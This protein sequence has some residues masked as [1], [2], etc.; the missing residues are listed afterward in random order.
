MSRQQSHAVAE[1]LEVAVF[2]ALLAD[3]GVPAVAV[4]VGAVIELS[5]CATVPIAAAIV[6][7]AALATLV[8]AE[9]DVAVRLRTYAALVVDADRTSAATVT[10]DRGA[11]RA[12]ELVRATVLLLLLG[13]LYEAVLVAGRTL[14]H[15]RRIGQLGAD[16][17]RLPQI[18]ELAGRFDYRRSRAPD[19]SLRACAPGDVAR[20]VVAAHVLKA[21]RRLGNFAD[22]QLLIRVLALALEA[23]VVLSN[24]KS[25]V[26]STTAS[27]V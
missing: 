8:L 9:S 11:V 25:A 23:P 14:R 16:R 7:A 18:L 1:V 17:A 12:D 4:V 15:P 2:V 3:R 5:V 22:L 6:V 27:N 10:R 21:E 19:V 26:L 24:F 20:L 13:V